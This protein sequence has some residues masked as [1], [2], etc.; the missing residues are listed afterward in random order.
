MTFSSLVR[1]GLVRGPALWPQA[2]PLPSASPTGQDHSSQGSQGH[3]PELAP[4][5]ER[6]GAL[7]AASRRS[8]PLRQAGP[9]RLRCPKQDLPT[10]H[11][12]QAP[13]QDFWM[14]GDEL[15][16]WSRNSWPWASEQGSRTCDQGYPWSAESNLQVPRPN[17]CTPEQDTRT[18]EWNSR[19]LRC[20]LSSDPGRLSSARSFEQRLPATQP[21][22]WTSPFS[23]PCS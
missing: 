17:P 4:A 9:A 2:H 14:A 22:K 6:K 11:T 8:H 21:P 10:P 23:Y 16:C 20:S 3:L 12:K 13:E 18:W 19:A 7:P 1:R 5:A 15:Q